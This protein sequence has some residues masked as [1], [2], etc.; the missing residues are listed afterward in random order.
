VWPHDNSLIACGLARSGRVD[1]A[2]TILRSMVEAASYFDYRLPEVFAGFDRERTRLPVAYP[3]ASHPQAW[4]AGAPILVLQTIL[5]LAPDRSTGELRTD[6][7]GLSGTFDGMRLRGVSA[8]GRR[9]D[10]SVD[11]GCATVA[12]A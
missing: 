2:E 5:G 10:V 9:W 11:D 7:T 4:A 6:A 12:A 3:T 1:D 8:F